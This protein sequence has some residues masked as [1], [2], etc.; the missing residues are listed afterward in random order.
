[1][2]IYVSFWVD[3][4]YLCD[5][6]MDCS[7]HYF[8]LDYLYFNFRKDL[9]CFLETFLAVLVYLFLQTVLRAMYF[10]FNSEWFDWKKNYILKKRCASFQN[11]L[12][13]VDKDFSRKD[14]LWEI[15]IFFIGLILHLFWHIFCQ[16]FLQSN[17]LILH[18]KYFHLLLLPLLWS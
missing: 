7:L 4:N 8:V 17:K 6:F 13:L 18:R 3:C 12:M 9:I 11:H 14:F 1:M 15:S 2:H 5:F 16:V 10:C